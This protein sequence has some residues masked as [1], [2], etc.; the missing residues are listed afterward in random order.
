[1]VLLL[2]HLY[3]CKS[4]IFRKDSPVYFSS[5]SRRGIRTE[6]PNPR[7]RQGAGQKQGKA[8]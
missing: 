8:A 4:M 6:R 2:G 3:H 7:H 1:M 5:L